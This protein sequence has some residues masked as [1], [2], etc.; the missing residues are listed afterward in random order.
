MNKKQFLYGIIGV[1]IAG[2]LAVVIGY[3]T[4]PRPV[5]ITELTSVNTSTA[6]EMAAETTTDETAIKKKP[7]QCCAERK[8]RLAKK[9][10][11]ARK[12]RLERQQAQLP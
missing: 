5:E 9:I 8:T 12:R 7:C 4:G 6:I 10:E 2:V 3:A 1:V 11:A